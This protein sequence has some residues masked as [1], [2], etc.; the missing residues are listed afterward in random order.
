MDEFF[1]SL[2]FLLKKGYFNLCVDCGTV[3]WVSFV[4]RSDQMSYSAVEIIMAFLGKLCSLVLCDFSIYMLNFW[5][6]ID[7]MG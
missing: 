4:Y 7:I 1:G 6:V 2:T 5:K 3:I